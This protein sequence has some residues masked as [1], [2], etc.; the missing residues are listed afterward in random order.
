MQLDLCPGTLGETG[1]PLNSTA[2]HAAEEIG[3]RTIAGNV[4]IVKNISPL[5]VPTEA[6]LTQETL[7]PIKTFLL[8]VLVVSVLVLAVVVP[9]LVVLAMVLGIVVA[10]AVAVLAAA[11]FGMVLLRGLQKGLGHKRIG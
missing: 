8:V 9:V 5:K 11:I 2:C 6:V 3:D 1:Q 4:V 7:L 10:V